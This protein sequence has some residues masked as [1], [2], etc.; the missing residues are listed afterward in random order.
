MS[1][2]LD[3]L[4]ISESTGWVSVP[5][6]RLVRC[7]LWGNSAGGSLVVWG[8][9]LILRTVAAGHLSSTW[10]GHGWH[11]AL[12]C[13]WRW[14]GDWRRFLIPGEV[15]GYDMLHDREWHKTRL[16]KYGGL[17]SICLLCSAFLFQ[18]LLYFLPKCG[19][20][21]S[22]PGEFWGPGS[23]C[24]PGRKGAAGDWAVVAPL[25]AGNDSCHRPACQLVRVDQGQGILERVRVRWGELRQV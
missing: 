18:I 5:G 6:S 1:D 22:W 9:D 14:G 2:K 15:L 4:I 24:Q 12:E 25:M 8:L 10:R 16:G 21:R 20:L 13:G 3:S 11:H 17:M 7:I 23:S 19:L